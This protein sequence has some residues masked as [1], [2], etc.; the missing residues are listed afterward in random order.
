MG[1]RLGKKQISYGEQLLLA[2]RAKT[3]KKGNDLHKTYKTSDMQTDSTQTQTKD[4][5]AETSQ[6]T[7]VIIRRE[8]YL[9]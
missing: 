6:K 5:A 1:G 4:A 2:A 7:A 9:N 8:R 3:A